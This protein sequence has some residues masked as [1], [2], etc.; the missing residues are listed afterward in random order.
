MLVDFVLS[1][2]IRFLSYLNNL[3]I[4][5]FS[6]RVCMAEY[7]VSVDGMECQGCERVVRSRLTDLSG[8]IDAVPDADNDEV[9]IY[10]DPAILEQIRW[11][12]TDAGYELP[13]WNE[14]NNSLIDKAQ[15]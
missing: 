1:Q 8:V 9:R 7:M 6:R 12:I 10:G 15:K 11:A 5:V 4:G 13:E 2:H 3:T 14:N